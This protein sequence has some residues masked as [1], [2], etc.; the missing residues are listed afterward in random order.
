[1]FNLVRHNFVIVEA[2]AVF[3]T[4]PIMGPVLLYRPRAFPAPLPNKPCFGSVHSTAHLKYVA[5]SM[6]FPFS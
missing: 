5:V 4:P 3:W 6:N 1:M 2:F